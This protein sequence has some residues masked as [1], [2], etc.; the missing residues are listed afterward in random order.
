MA[1]SIQRWAPA[2]LATLS[3][4][5]SP[6][7]ASA[8]G[9]EHVGELSVT[10][11]F[12]QEPAYAGLPNSVQVTLERGGEPVV[13]ARQLS[14]DVAF[15]DATATYDMEPNF[16]VGVFGEPGD[17]RAFFVP[18]EPGPYTFHVT[19]TVGQEDVDVEMTSGGDTFAEVS[20]IDE[21]AFPPVEAPSAEELA[22]RIETESERLTAAAADASSAR[23]AVA[24]ARTIAIVGLVVGAI[25]AIA[26][27]GA[28]AAIR[29]RSQ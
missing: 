7:A 24:A 6:S 27:I 21:A 20:S 18:S 3:V 29:R 17:Y 19:G 5:L 23:D 22:G 26:A 11:G 15:G 14:V 9:E 2:A 28:L 4:L 16:V 12:G 10:I 13:D 1:R 25:G 8:H